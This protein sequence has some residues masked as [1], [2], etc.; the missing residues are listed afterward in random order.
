MQANR[1]SCLGGVCAFSYELSA[2]VKEK[3]IGCVCL[4]SQDIA[5]YGTPKIKDKCSAISS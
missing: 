5:Y 2:D 4:L 3:Y 1:K